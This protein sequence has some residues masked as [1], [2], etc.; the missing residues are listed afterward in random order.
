MSIEYDNYLKKH[1]SNVIK[2]YEWLRKNLPELFETDIDYDVWKNIYCHDQSKYNRNEYTAYDSY[3]YGNNKSFSVV[4]NFKYAWLLHIHNS[5]HHWQYWVL[6]SDDP[7]E[8]EN[9]LEMPYNYIIEMICDWWSFSWGKGDLSE[10]FNWYDKHNS[11][12]KLAPKTKKTV[13]D[14]LWKIRDRLGYNATANRT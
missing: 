3:F 14:I 11:Y 9:I 13:E 2:G 6:N 7:D 4:N 8:G 10:V 5:P 12:I 1:C